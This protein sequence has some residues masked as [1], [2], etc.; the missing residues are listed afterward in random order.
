MSRGPNRRPKYARET[1]KIGIGHYTN[2]GIS[3]TTATVFHIATLYCTYRLHGLVDSLS[4]MRTKFFIFFL[5]YMTMC[6]IAYRN[7]FVS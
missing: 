2:I 3:T 5:T 1:A 4:Q 7:H 6:Y